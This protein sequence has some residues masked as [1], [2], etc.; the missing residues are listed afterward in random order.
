MRL[1]KLLTISNSIS[2]PWPLIGSPTKQNGSAEEGQWQRTGRTACWLNRHDPNSQLCLQPSLGSLGNPYKTG[3]LGSGLCLLKK[4]F[5]SCGLEADD[6]VESVKIRRIESSTSEGLQLNA[7]T[8]QRGMALS[9]H[10]V[11]GVG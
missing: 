5:P 2:E 1:L 6:L 10:Q 9:R 3:Q 11:F 8:M 7:P 4:Q